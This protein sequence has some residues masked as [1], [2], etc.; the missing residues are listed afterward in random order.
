[1]K[2]KW[3]RLGG[4]GTDLQLYKP[5][6]ET[7]WS[8]RWTE[9]WQSV[10]FREILVMLSLYNRVMTQSFSSV[11]QSC[12]TLCNPMNCSMPDFPVFHQLPECAQTHIHRIGDAIHPSYPLSSPSPPAFN[13]SQHQG[14]TRESPRKAT[15]TRCSPKLIEKKK[16]KEKFGSPIWAEL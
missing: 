2:V 15:E 10:L 7:H 1:M 11:A 9:Y 14:A 4:I 16:R 6:T 3:V 8:D 5:Q 13:L 12:L